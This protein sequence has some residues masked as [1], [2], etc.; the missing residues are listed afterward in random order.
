[1]NEVCLTEYMFSISVHNI[2][3]K[4]SASAVHL[5]FEKYAA[6]AKKWGA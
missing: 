1:M 2:Q 4:F 5:I 3:F 6:R